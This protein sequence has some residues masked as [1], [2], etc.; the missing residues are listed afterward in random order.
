MVSETRTRN[1]DEQLE[2]WSV[3]EPEGSAAAIELINGNLIIEA[4][5]CMV[6]VG[7]KRAISLNE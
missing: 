4:V 6:A 1:V 3:Y 5:K 7:P 2:A